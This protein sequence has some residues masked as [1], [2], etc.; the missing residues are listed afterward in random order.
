MFHITF[1]FHD[2]VELHKKVSFLFC[3]K[4]FLSHN[5]ELLLFVSY[6]FSSARG[7]E[8]NS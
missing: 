6:S 1:L 3:L 8:R 4:L 2:Q 7:D 5:Q